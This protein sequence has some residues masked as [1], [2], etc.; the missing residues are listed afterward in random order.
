MQTLRNVYTVEQFATEV[1]GGSRLP[2]WVR[3]QCR[4]KEIEVVASRPYLIPQSEAVKF[5]NPEGKR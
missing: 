3:K 5:I 1:L 4:L 2:A